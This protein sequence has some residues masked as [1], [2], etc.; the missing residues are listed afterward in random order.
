MAV[1]VVPFF[2]MAATN[3]SKKNHTG[4]AIGGGYLG[5]PTAA[6]LWHLV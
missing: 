1:T 3:D 6:R 2:E 5:L 4:T